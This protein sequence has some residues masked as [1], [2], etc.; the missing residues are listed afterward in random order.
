MT[1]LR[2]PGALAEIGRAFDADDRLRPDRMDV[3]DPIRTKVSSAEAYLANAQL[4]P[5]PRRSSGRQSILFDRRG[6]PR[7]GG[8]VDFTLAAAGAAEYAHRLYLATDAGESGWFDGP[9]HLGAMGE[10]FVRLAGAF[11]AYYGF[12]TDG[13][14]PR[15]QMAEF[16]RARLQGEEAL[17]IPAP[18]TDRTSLRDVYWLMLFGPS[19]VE[20]FGAGLQG[21]G[22]RRQETSNGGL[23][24]WA[25]ESP[26]VVRGVDSVGHGL[27][28]EEVVP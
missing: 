16:G 5:S 2:R 6:E 21:L 3:R 11:D 26:V 24:I 23:V 22:V 18:F 13:R 20:R 25:A 27:R 10:L 9:D 8:A 15:Q 19:Y 1:D 4:A 12:V 7:C 14:L 17:S 28:M